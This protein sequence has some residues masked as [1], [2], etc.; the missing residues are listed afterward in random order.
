[1]STLATMRTELARALRDPDQKTFTVNELNDLIN[2]G[3]SALSR[4]APREAVDTT[5]F[6]S[7]GVNSYTTSVTFTQI[8]RVDRYNS[9]G[10]YQDTLP[11]ST[12]D[13]PN[14]GWDLHAGVLFLP[15][16]RTWT[17]GD[18][19]YCFGYASF[20]QLLTDSDAFA[21]DTN[22]EW[23]VIVFGQVEGFSRLLSDR[24]MFQQWQANPGNTDVTALSLGQIYRGAQQRW[25][26]EK[27]SLRRL[28]KVG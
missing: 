22:G 1:M 25:D 10:V 18:Q 24:T 7:V 2:Q 5:V 20:A 19:L 12:G 8:F 13:G 6:L 4:F 23:A 28:R 26:E 15:P 9:L 21:G 3:I 11:A 14:S 27:R 16:T 17:T